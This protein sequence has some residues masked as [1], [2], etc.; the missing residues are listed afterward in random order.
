VKLVPPRG[1]QSILRDASPTGRGGG[2][3]A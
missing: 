2:R 3:P 1:C